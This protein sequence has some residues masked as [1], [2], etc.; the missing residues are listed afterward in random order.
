M[1]AS[2]CQSLILL[3]FTKVQFMPFKFILGLI[4]LV[5]AII[6]AQIKAR[7]EHL[8]ILKSHC[9]VPFINQFVLNLFESKIYPSFLNKSAIMKQN[10]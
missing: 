1:S 9:N 2:E 6:I 4:F 5:L 3:Y 7:A 10:T 8:C